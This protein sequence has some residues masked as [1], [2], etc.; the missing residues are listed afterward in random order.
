M[1]LNNF[2]PSVV[3]IASVVCA[4]KMM[5][6]D[7]HWHKYL[8]QLSGYPFKLIS[9]AFSSLYKF[10]LNAYKKVKEKENIQNRI[11]DAET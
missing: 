11:L 7:T 4:R 6:L 10:Y 8:G 3:T 1:K 9:D 5:K 2:T